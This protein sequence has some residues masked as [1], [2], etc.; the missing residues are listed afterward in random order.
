MLLTAPEETE[1]AKLIQTVS[2]GREVRWEFAHGLIRQTLESSLS[3]PRRQRAHLRVAEAMERVYGTHAARRGSR[4]VSH[5]RHA[6]APRN[7][8]ADGGGALTKLLETSVGQGSALPRRPEGLRHTGNPLSL[9]A[10][11]RSEGM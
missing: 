4:D 7:G 10:T 2:A 8:R 11:A 5:D 1:A 6:E 9:D 3:L